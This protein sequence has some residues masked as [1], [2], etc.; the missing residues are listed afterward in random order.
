MDVQ[1]VYAKGKKG[2]HFQFGLDDGWAIEEILIGLIAF[3][4]ESMHRNRI[5]ARP[6]VEKLM[7]AEL[8]TRQLTEIR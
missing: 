8:E 2:F 5:A 7:F 6:A 4:C 1:E 3:Y